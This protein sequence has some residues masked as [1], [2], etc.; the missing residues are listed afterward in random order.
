MINNPHFHEIIN[1][2]SLF[3]YFFN[4]AIREAWEKE[5]VTKI[6]RSFLLS[7][8][9]EDVGFCSPETIFAEE[10][11]CYCVFEDTVH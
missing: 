2:F 6:P 9:E 4:R 1:S 5:E 3:L 10:S 7:V 11:H 8:P